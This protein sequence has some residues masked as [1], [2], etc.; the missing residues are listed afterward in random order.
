MKT[1]LEALADGWERAAR[2]EPRGAIVPGLPPEQ[3]EESGRVASETVAAIIPPGTA[4][5]IEFGC[6]DGRIT[7]HL[8]ALYG[9]VL[10]VDI[11]PTM[12]THVLKLGLPNVETY[13]SDGLTMPAG[14]TFDAAYSEIVLIHNTYEDG[15]RIIKA[16]AGAIADGG[17]LALHIPVYDVGRDPEHWI[18]VGVWTIDQ[19][20][21]AADSAGCAVEQFWTN[22]GSF[23]FDRIGPN[24][25]KLQVLRKLS[26]SRA[27][28]LIH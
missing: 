19:L 6:G 4:S 20:T 10:A 28:T 8:A 7:R 27:A 18:D 22:S 13:L 17:L 14:R 1:Q 12:L 16:L 2:E 15:R 26:S 21:E 25:Y 11:A 23:G 3:Y 9:V 5:V 24:H